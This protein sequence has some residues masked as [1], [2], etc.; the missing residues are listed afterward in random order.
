[1]NKSEALANVGKLTEIEYERL[2]GVPDNFTNVEVNGRRISYTKRCSLM[3]N[4]WNEPTI[5]HIFKGLQIQWK[6]SLRI[7]DIK[8]G[9]WYRLKNTSGEYCDYYGW[10]NV[11][12]IYK[13][14]DYRSP[15]K[16]KSLVKCRHVVNMND[17][18]GFIRYFSPSDIINTDECKRMNREYLNTN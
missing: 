13:R 17:T 7:Q 1:M 6:I 9:N 12:D 16:K 4:A 11:I 5:E 18:C 2:Q 10:I 15:D 3:G 14:G 8:V